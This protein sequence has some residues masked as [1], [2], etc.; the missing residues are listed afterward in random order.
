MIAAL[1]LKVVF[2]GVAMHPGG[3]VWLARAHGKSVIGLPGAP[4][5]AMIAARLVLAPL[6]AVIAGAAATSAL[7]W[8]RET[9]RT[10]LAR[11]GPVVAFLCA[12]RANDGVRALPGDAA[13]RADLDV[14]IRRRAGAAASRCGSDIEALDF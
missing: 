2:G 12:R 8:R 13:T 4:L 10:G 1:G 5:A 14:L 11:G 9:T 7:V 6:L 3:S